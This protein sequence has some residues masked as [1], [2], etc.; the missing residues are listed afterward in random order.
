MNARTQL[1]APGLVY[2][3]VN[4]DYHAVP[5]LGASGLKLLARSPAHYFGVML[6]PARPQSEPSPAM[7][8]GTLAH[9]AI[10]EPDELAARY[11]VKPEGVDLR[12]KDGKAWVAAVTAGVEIMT[13]EQRET[14]IRQAAAVRALPEICDLLAG[15]KPEVS[16]FWT[17]AA[18]GEL[19]KCRPDW[20]ATLDEGVILVDVKTA[21]DASPAGFA[22]AVANFG[23][24][25]QAAWYVNGYEQASGRRVLGFVFAVVESNYPHAAAAYML[26]DEDTERAGADNRRLLDLY[27][28]CKRAN[29][30]P[31]YPSAI[32]QLALPPWTFS[33]NSESTA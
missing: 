5:A 21:Q 15:G 3:M 9:C 19:C 20:V 10:L 22:K 29:A 25:R 4:A 30:W 13:A 28:A 33:F 8:A 17:D 24:H 11:V 27:V 6:D 2:G 12:T 14:A 31:G 32:Q 1:P 23:Y 16:A 26:T 7:R 18:T